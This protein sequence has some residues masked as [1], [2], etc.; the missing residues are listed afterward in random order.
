MDTDLACQLG[1]ESRLLPEPIPVRALDGHLLGTITSITSPISMMISG[2]HRE[3]ICF[4]LLRSPNQPLI[5][6][7]PW[8][9]LH[10]PHLDWVSG[11]I[12]EWGE[13]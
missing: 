1:V 2:N 9:R 13:R 7:S 10:N 11:T 8:L 3:T 6:G 5:L 12:K 4:H